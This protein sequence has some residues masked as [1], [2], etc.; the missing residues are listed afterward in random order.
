M[1]GGKL[2]ERSADRRTTRLWAA[3]FLHYRSRHVTPQHCNNVRS[4]PHRIHTAQSR[5]NMPSRPR[6]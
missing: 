1:Y 6:W 3:S 2:G 5:M 4:V